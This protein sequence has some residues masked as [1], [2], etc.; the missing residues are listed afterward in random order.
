MASSFF[1]LAN[2]KTLE[3]STFLSP[4]RRSWQL[5]LNAATLYP[6]IS[7]LIR[8]SR[9]PWRDFPSCLLPGLPAPTLAP[10]Y[11]FLHTVSHSNPF[12]NLGLTTS[13]LITLQWLPPISLRIKSKVLPLACKVLLG[14]AAFCQCLRHHS[15]PATLTNL[16]FPPPETSFSQTSSSFLS[17]LQVC[18]NVTLFKIAITSDPLSLLVTLPCF[19]S[20][21]AIITASHV[22]VFYRRFPSPTGTQMRMYT[23]GN[24]AVCVLTV[25]CSLHLEQGL[26][27]GRVSVNIL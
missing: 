22:F 11:S 26:I 4:V 24:Q 5:Q 16:S 9:I 23:P 21:L 14:G 13:L 6:S 7:L 1:Q 18:S 19:V 15:A 3:S 2:P 17:S 12:K 25:L 10:R 27:P 20:L 8:S